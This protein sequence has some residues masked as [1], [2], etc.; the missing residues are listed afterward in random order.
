M[1]RELGPNLKVHLYVRSDLYLLQELREV[2]YDHSKGFTTQSKV[3][4][5]LLLVTHI[6]IDIYSNHLQGKGRASK[7]LNS[8]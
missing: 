5:W 7:N 4:V 8:K 6:F 1:T 2:L 3:I